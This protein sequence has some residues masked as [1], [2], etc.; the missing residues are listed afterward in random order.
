MVLS[1]HLG[2]IG[3]SRNCDVYNFITFTTDHSYF[4]IREHNENVLS[5]KI[6]FFVRKY[7]FD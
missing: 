2:H 4:E 5:C 7:R 6:T 1:Y 3:S